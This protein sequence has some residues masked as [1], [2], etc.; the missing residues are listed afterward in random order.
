MS[1]VRDTA[2][3]IPLNVWQDPQGDVVAR[4][5]LE[6]CHIYF[7][8]WEAAGRPAKYCCELTFHDACAVR[9]VRLGGAPYK[10][11]PPY[12]RSSILMVEASQWLQEVI[13]LQLEYYPESKSRDRSEYLHYAVSGHDI[14]YDI[15]ATGFDERIVPEAEAGEFL[16]LI[17]EA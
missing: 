5:S 4:Y 3:Q 1:K 2:I 15:I 11:N 16:R 8:C 12:L 10:I 13:A 7:G 14:Y 9:G 17:R 6:E